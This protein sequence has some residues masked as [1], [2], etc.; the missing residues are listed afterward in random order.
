[1]LDVL[2]SVKQHKPSPIQSNPSLVQA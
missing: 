2:V 1:M